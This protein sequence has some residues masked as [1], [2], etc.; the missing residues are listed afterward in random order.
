MS[1]RT[2]PED[3]I[4]GIGSILE[5]GGSQ[6]VT[7][8][9]EEIGVNRSTAS[10]YLPSL[11]EAGF[12]TVEEHGREKQYC[13]KS[14]GVEELYTLPDLPWMDFQKVLEALRFAQEHAVTREERRNLDELEQRLLEGSERREI[15]EEPEKGD[16]H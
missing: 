13:L 16:T 4:T 8:I 6:S 5:D 2:S 3:V 7:Q 14:K 10:K 1:S 11:V 12:L 9:T 15:G